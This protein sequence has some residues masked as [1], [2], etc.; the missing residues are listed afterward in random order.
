VRISEIVFSIGKT[1]PL[2]P[3]TGN[4]DDQYSNVKPFASCKVAFGPGE[5]PDPSTKDGQRT[6]DKAY[7]HARDICVNQ[8]VRF[9]DKFSGMV[10]GTKPNTRRR[11]V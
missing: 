6:L 2:A 5:S 9:H 8:L 10:S 4:S 1:T 3:L 7:E 11:K